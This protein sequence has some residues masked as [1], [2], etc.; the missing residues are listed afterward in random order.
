MQQRRGTTAEWNGVA[1]TVILAAGEIGFVT[2]G[3]DAGK[4]KIGDGT[5]T[6]SQ[7]PFFQNETTL[8][9]NLL[10]TSPVTISQDP[11]GAQYTV[12]FDQT[13]QNTTN[14][15]RY[16]KLEGNNTTATTF[17]AKTTTSIPL[18]V[19]GTGVQTGNL[20]EWQSSGSTTPL[21]KVDSAGNLTAATLVSNGTITSTGNITAATATASADKLRATNTSADANASDAPIVAGD[22][23]GVHIGISKNGIAAVNNTGTSPLNVQPFG[24]NTFINNGAG[25]NVTIG[26][27]GTS[28]VTIS[29]TQATIGTSTTTISSQTINMGDTSG[30]GQAYILANT[31]GV[32][33]TALNIGTSMSTSTLNIGR[34]GITTAIQGPTTI[35]GTL[36][37]TNKIGYTQTS[38]TVTQGTSKTTGVTLNNLSGTI[39]TANTSL[40]ALV[41]GTSP[42]IT[43]GGVATFTLTNS[44]IAATDIV[45]I[46]VV[47]G[48]ANSANA[49]AYAVSA[50]PATG[51]AAISIR[52]ITGGA[53]AEAV[54]LRFVVIKT[55]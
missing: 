37:A 15:I 33:G 23:A 8:G 53:L 34:S 27:A 10:T 46:S 47:S 17:V 26:T 42:A 41:V 29:G 14:D 5:K 43:S 7:L 39:T 22:V 25:G 40:S 6:W 32:D 4:F 49:A 35:A 1:S 3:D 55:T 38:N 21:S 54:Q 45:L 16:A 20:Q 31:V 30:G 50:V 44:F 2:S 28:T 24:G 13:A 19:K 18:T 51:S 11:V 48:T 52:N 12:G 36:S 9:S